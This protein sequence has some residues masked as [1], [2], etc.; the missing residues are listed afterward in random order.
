MRDELFLLEK[1]IHEILFIFHNPSHKPH[2]ELIGLENGL[3]TADFQNQSYMKLTLL[4]HIRQERR[5]VSPVIF[6]SSLKF[7]GNLDTSEPGD[8]IVALSSI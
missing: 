1:T 3:Y 4:G 7:A 6:L 8:L 2:R 5:R